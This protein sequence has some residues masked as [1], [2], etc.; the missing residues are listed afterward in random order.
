MSNSGNE[1]SPASRTM[2]ASALLGGS[3][4]VITQWSDY[5]QG[6]IDVQQLSKKVL[7]DAA[8]A[9]VAGGIATAVASQMAGRPLLSFTTLLAAGA[10]GLYLID[11]MKEKN[12]G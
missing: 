6:E 1:L 5:Q 9:G 7:K 4:S 2:L 11:E 10:A 8:K 3:A 12:H